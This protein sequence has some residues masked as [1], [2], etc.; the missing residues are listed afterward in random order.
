MTS[1]KNYF[2]LCYTGRFVFNLP[3]SLKKVA[4]M[5]NEMLDSPPRI[6]MVQSDTR[7]L[8]QFSSLLSFDERKYF[9]LG[10]ANSD[11]GADWQI[12]MLVAV[13]H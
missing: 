11:N 3:F 8:F 1:H 7:K 12:A 10:A 2:P 13:L 4:L 5:L 6:L 9:I